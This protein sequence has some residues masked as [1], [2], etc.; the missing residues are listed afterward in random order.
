VIVFFLFENTVCAELNLLLYNVIQDLRH[1]KWRYLYIL[2]YTH[3]DNLFI[4]QQFRIFN[5]VILYYIWFLVYV[6]LS[7]S[8]ETRCFIHMREKIT[9]WNL[10]VLYNKFL[11]I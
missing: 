7:T 3:K 6:Y 1:W 5:I 10:S 8:L 9:L 4:K 2:G 11:K